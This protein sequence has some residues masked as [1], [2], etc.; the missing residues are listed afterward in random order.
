MR[1]S[2]VQLIFMV[3]ALG[4]VTQWKSACA[5]RNYTPTKTLQVV[6]NISWVSTV[7]TQ[8]PDWSETDQGVSLRWY[9]TN[10]LPGS[11]AQ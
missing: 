11:T 7:I 8:V 6:C 9:F 3:D 10:K 1:R 5:Y 4:S 2:P